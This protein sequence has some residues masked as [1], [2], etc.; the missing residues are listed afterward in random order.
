MKWWPWL[1]AGATGVGIGVAIAARR[2]RVVVRVKPVEVGALPATYKGRLSP[3]EL[4][5]IDT[6]V[7]HQTDAGGGFGL[8]ARQL[9]AQREDYQAALAKRYDETPYHGVFSP[10][11][12]DVGRKFA[13]PGVL[14]L[15]WPAWAYTFHGHGSNASSVG[16]AYDGKVPG[17]V[18]DV[19]GA[20]QAFADFVEQVRKQGA[21]LRYVEAHAQH[22]SDRHGDPGD[23]IWQ[24][25]ILPTLPGLGLTVRRRTTGTGSLPAWL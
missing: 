16:F 2:R 3:R 15:N 11:T 14:F 20:R 22:S 4:A 13:S 5:A 10:R 24:Q 18:I 1:L 25:V 7:I 12:S 19:D 23:A 21:P 9:S 6:V 17:D 8:T